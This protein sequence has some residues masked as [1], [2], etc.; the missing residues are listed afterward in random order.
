MSIYTDILKKY[1]VNLYEYGITPKTPAKDIKIY[2]K[3]RY[4]Y[5]AKYLPGILAPS[6]MRETAGI[7]VAID[8]KNE[9]KFNFACASC[10][11]FTSRF[12]LKASLCATASS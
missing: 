4:Q 5:M 8:F 9:D 11:L 2:P 1:G 7:Q 12:P 6:M 10:A 3:K